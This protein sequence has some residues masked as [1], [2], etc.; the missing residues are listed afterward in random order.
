LLALLVAIVGASSYRLLRSTFLRSFCFLF[1]AGV[2]HGILD[3]FTNGGLGVAF[4]WPWSAQRFFA[5][6]QVIEVSPIGISRF[7]SPKGI[8]VLW[9]E[10][11]WVWLP[12]LSVGSALAIFRYRRALTSS[13]PHTVQ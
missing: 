12:F 8:A 5:P 6:I 11:L 2:S 13:S 3:A 10:M 9:S 7:L 1:V 4:L